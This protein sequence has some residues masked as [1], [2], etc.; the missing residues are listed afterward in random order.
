MLLLGSEEE[1]VPGHNATHGNQVKLERRLPRQ[2][3]NGPPDVPLLF[4]S[5]ILMAGEKQSAKE[6]CHRICSDFLGQETA[7]EDH[8]PPS[9]CSR[10]DRTS[11][12]DRTL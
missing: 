12:Y 8:V 2:D 6:S 4:R 3:E 5:K 9:S 11:R 7:G 10:R 1:S